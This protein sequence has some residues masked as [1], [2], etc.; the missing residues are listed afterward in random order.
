MILLGRS[1]R[2]ARARSADLLELDRYV[3]GDSPFH[4]ADA[5]LKFIL[6]IA[7]ILGDLAAAHR[8]GLALLITWLTLVAC[9]ATA[10]L[11]PFRLSRSAVV[12]L[13]FTLA[14]LPLDVHESRSRSSGRRPRAA[15]PDDLRRGPAA[16]PHDRDRELAVGAGGPAARLHHAVPRPHR[17]AARA[18]PARGSCVSIIS[19]HVPLPRASSATRARACCGPRRPIGGRAGGAGGGSIRWRATR[20]RADGRVAV[21]ARLRAQRAD[22]RR[23]AGARVRGRVPPPASTGPPAA[24]ARLARPLARLLAASR[25]SPPVWLPRHVTAEPHV[26]GHA[27]RGRAAGHAHPHVHEPRPRPVR[28]HIVPSRPGDAGHGRGTVDLEHV[29]FRYPD[30]F[31]ALRGVDLRIGAGEKVALVGPNGAGKSTL[32]LQLNGTL[33]PEHGSVRVGGPGRGQGDDPARPCRGG[34]R[35]PGSRRPAV[36]PDR[37][38]RRRL[39][40]RSTWAL[41]ADEIHGRVERALAAVGMAAFAHRVPHRMSLGPAEASGAGHGAVDGPVDP[42]LRRAVRRPGPARAPRADRPAA[43]R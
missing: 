32:M 25:S 33:R 26:H 34:P 41:P 13:P 20:D 10:G 6:T 30:G 4:R 43:R 1:S 39:R 5:R 38:R 11:G 29:H 24:R 15:R 37:V 2:A 9:S 40:A 23:D 7:G 35:L 42:G 3:E 17:R 18:A 19:L 16:L 12:A 8:L 28:P 31:E 21:P 22:L 27:P 14:A 36:Q